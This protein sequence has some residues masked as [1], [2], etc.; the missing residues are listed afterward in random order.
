MNE[1]TVYTDCSHYK[2]VGSWSVLLKSDDDQL[3][4]SGICPQYVQTAAQGEAYAVFKSIELAK[5]LFPNHKKLKIHTDCIGLCFVLQKTANPQK[6]SVNRM[7]Q[8]A[9]LTNLV[10][11]GYE[12]EVLFVRSHQGDNLVSSVYNDLVDTHARK[13]R[14][15][16]QNQNKTTRI[17]RYL[18]KLTYFGLS[19]YYYF[20]FME[21]VFLPKASAEFNPVLL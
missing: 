1:L 20:R 11:W 12:W 2:K 9:I 16:N 17:Q 3:I 14:K 6:S 4:I 13:I 5:T 15:K 10:R 18:K 7:I 21:R 19:N 8:N